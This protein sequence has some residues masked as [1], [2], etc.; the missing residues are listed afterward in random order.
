MREV[1]ALNLHAEKQQRKKVDLV[2]DWIR[3][4]PEYSQIVE[5][6]NNR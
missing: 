1:Q 4:L 6:L 2:R 5:G 3:S